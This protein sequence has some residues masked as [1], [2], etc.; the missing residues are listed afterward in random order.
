M[1]ISE[2]T[3]LTL[4]M[5]QTLLRNCQPNHFAMALGRATN[6]RACKKKSAMV[7]DRISH[8]LFGSSGDAQHHYEVCDDAK[9]SIRAL[10]KH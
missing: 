8:S 7:V 3:R 4:A 2:K 5:L 6:L 9:P 10:E 1:G